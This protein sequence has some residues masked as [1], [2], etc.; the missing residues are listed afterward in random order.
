MQ[1]AEKE[2]LRLATIELFMF[3]LSSISLE[4]DE[5]RIF[6]IV[7]EKAT[8]MQFEDE[9]VSQQQ[10]A[11]GKLKP[12]KHGAPLIDV[13]GVNAIADAEGS[14]WRQTRKLSMFTVRHGLID[15]PFIWAS[16]IAEQIIKSLGID[17]HLNV[18]LH[19]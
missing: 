8:I 7:K 1:I 18:D 5:L 14:D 10:T 6:M 13:N 3:I 11:S 9:N 4:G 17:W 15:G 12:D 16:A 19:G 2:G